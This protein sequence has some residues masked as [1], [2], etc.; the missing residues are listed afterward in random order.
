M[1]T[2][3]INRLRNGHS[4]TP[5]YLYKFGLRDHPYCECDETAIGDVNHTCHAKITT[6]K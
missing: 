4:V 2:V 1:V 3:H 6:Q 5:E